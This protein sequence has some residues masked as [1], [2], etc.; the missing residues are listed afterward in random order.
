[1]KVGARTRIPRRSPSRSSPA[2]ANPGFLVEIEAV[3]A[4]T[5]G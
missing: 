1:M 2:L 3:G 5:S 4:L